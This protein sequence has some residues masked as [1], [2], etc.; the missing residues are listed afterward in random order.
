MQTFLR[1]WDEVDTLQYQRGYTNVMFVPELKRLQAEL[2]APP[3]NDDTLRAKVLDNFA[4]L[5]RF[6]RAL[7]KMAAVDHPELARLLPTLD[8]PGT[9]D[10]SALIVPRQSPDRAPLLASIAPPP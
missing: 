8:S 4:L 1:K 5:E 9:L 6:A 3:M 7:Q 2:T 10:I